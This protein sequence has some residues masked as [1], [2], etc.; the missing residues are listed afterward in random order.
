MLDPYTALITRSSEHCEAP[1]F[2]RG[3][4]Y[5]EMTVLI[6]ARAPLNKVRA[7]LPCAKVRGSRS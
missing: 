5:P 2:L 4:S 1:A 7:P 6:K 3:V